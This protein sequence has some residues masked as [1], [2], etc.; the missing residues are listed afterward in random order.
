MTL[1]ERRKR[2]REVKTAMS[3]ALSYAEPGD[4]WDIERS[5]QMVGYGLLLLNWLA[6]DL[7]SD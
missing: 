6:A 3:L 4:L 5:D 7:I 2:I 1:T